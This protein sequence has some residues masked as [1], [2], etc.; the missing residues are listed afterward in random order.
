MYI[1]EGGYPMYIGEGGTLCTWRLAIPPRHRIDHPPGPLPPAKRP[2]K[3]F[4]WAKILSSMTK[5]FLKNLKYFLGSELIFEKKC[6]KKGVKIG[7]S[8]VLPY[9]TLF[10]HIFRILPYFGPY[11]R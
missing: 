9:F 3:V 5:E 2:K 4:F 7:V 11:F 10:H 8:T 1:G 6:A